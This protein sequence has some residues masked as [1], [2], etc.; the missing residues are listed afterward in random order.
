MAFPHIDGLERHVV[1]GEF[2]RQ[3]LSLTHSLRQRVDA[4]I[5]QTASPL[6][7]AAQ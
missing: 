6:G 7:N 1:N 5:T 2:T 4:P 3:S